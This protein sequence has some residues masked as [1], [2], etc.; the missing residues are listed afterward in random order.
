MIGVDKCGSTDLFDKIAKHPDVLKNG[1]ALKKETMWWSWLRYGLLFLA[2]WCA[3]FFLSSVDVFKINFFENYFIRNTI[4]L[5]QF[6]PDQ[7]R[8]E[9]RA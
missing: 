3:C 2:T 5:K 9:S 7:A 1:G 6:D 4:S 8:R